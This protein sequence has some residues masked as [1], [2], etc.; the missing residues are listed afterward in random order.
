LI[1]QIGDIDD[2]EL[3]M[4]A[5][6]NLLAA[7]GDQING[8]IATGYFPL[9]AIATYLAD[10]K[11]SHIIGV[12]IDTDEKVL[13]AIRAGSL[14]GTMSQN[15]YGQAYICTLALKMLVDGWT[16]KSTES[17]HIDSGSFL[18]TKD[19]IDELDKLKI[20]V[21]NEILRTWTARF[22]PPR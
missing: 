5:V 22:N 8:I 6:K 18:I 1:Q 9:V 10:P 14:H 17:K 11:Y 12:G 15:P 20:D 21:T 7:Q 4:T 2:A 3:S 16:Y 13:D 19:N